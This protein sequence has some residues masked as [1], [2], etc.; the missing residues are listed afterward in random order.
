MGSCFVRE[1][2]RALIERGFD[3]PHP[4]AALAARW[5]HVHAGAATSCWLAGAYANKFNTYS[6][7]YEVQRACLGPERAPEFVQRID[8]GTWFDIGAANVLSDT[9][10]AAVRAR[11]SILDAHSSHIT[12]CDIFVLTLG[13][14]E[15]WFNRRLGINDQTGA[16]ANTSRA[17]Y[18][19]VALDFNEHMEALE[20]L[21]RTVKERNPACRFIV[22][23]SPIPLQATFSGQDIVLANMYSKATLRSVAGAFCARHQYTDYFPSFEMVMFSDPSVVWQPDRRH[24]RREL[25]AEI[26]TTFLGAYLCD[27]P[28]RKEPP[29]GLHAA[30]GNT[31]ECR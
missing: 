23:V 19:F 6:M 3:V 30:S 26:V 1:I 31:V 14:T 12:R 28:S 2:E 16:L 27:E 20:E 5:P 17:D 10:E 13:L 18:E 21:H 15:G 8:D 29:A 4:G 9:S 7:L 25:V 22:T 24:V 11:R